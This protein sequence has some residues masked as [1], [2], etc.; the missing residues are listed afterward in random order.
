MGV[1][2]TTWDG[3]WKLHGRCA[4]AGR[5]GSKGG[6]QP[7]TVAPSPLTAGQEGA[8]NPPLPSARSA[9]GGKH[10]GVVGEGRCE[11]YQVSAPHPP[12]PDEPSLP[13]QWVKCRA[14]P[15]RLQSSIG[16]EREARA[17]CTPQAHTDTGMD[18]SSRRVHTRNT[19]CCATSGLVKS[20]VCSSHHQITTVNTHS[21]GCQ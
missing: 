14:N 3:R 12:C 20:P 18:T 13:A 5:E 7:A 15:V 11:G 10:W 17:R 16:P 8:S 2:T 19:D 21:S 9:L 1:T 6:L 4:E